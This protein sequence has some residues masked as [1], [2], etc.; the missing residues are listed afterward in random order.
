MIKK[1]CNL[2]DVNFNILLQIMPLLTYQ[3]MGYLTH[4]C[5]MLRLTLSAE[6]PQ[7]DIALEEQHPTPF[8]AFASVNN[9]GDRPSFLHGLILPGSTYNMPL[10]SERQAMSTKEIK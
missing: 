10:S 6:L 3:D 4:T 2:P 1:S 9:R 5:H 8:R 7:R